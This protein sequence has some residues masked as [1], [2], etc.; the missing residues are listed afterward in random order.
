MVL[1]LNNP[2]SWIFF[3]KFNISTS[4]DI[5]LVVVLELVSFRS[6]IKANKEEFF[7]FIIK[8]GSSLIG[9]MSCM[10][11]LPGLQVWGARFF[12]APC[13]LTCHSLHTPNWRPVEQ[14]NITIHHFGP[15]FY[16]QSFTF[17]MSWAMLKMFRFF[18]STT[19][20]C[21]GDLD[22]ITGWRFP[23]SSQILLNSL[24]VNS[25]P[26]LDLIALISRH[27]PFQQAFKISWKYQTPR[28]FHFENKSIFFY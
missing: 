2:P 7:I 23:F 19:S 10:A 25:P 26:L 13:F 20:F 1:F 9:H 28:I 18:L 15:V 22:T 17:S 11:M 8:L 4:H 3:I 5:F 12:F 27:F 6:W 16:L 14:I 24:Y 21:W